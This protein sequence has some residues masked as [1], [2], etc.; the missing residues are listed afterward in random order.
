MSVYSVSGGSKGS[1]V[2]DQIRVVGVFLLGRVVLQNIA[3]F[4]LRCVLNAISSHPFEMS[5]FLRVLY[6]L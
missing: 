5:S 6:D 2:G 3:G 1:G 4:P